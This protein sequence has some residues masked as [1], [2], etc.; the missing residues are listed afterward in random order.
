MFAE[1]RNTLLK[2]GHQIASE[3]PNKQEKAKKNSPSIM[4][5]TGCC[6]LASQIL[7]DQPTPNVTSEIIHHLQK[8]NSSFHLQTRLQQQKPVRIHPDMKSDLG[9]DQVVPLAKVA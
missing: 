4:I 7:A 6:L 1:M 3:S 9:N 8:C 2:V 5:G